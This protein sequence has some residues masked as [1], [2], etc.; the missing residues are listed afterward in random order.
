MGDQDIRWKQ[1]FDSFSKALRQ[2]KDGVDL[3]ES[4]SLS[5][6]EEQGLIQG[7]EFT[8]ELAWK[9]LKDF[10]ESK[11]NTVLYGSK[12]VTRKAYQLELIEDGESWMQMIESRNLSSHTYNE[13]T[14]EKIV[15]EILTKYY[16]L[17]SSLEVKMN[18]L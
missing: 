15:S 11:G 4:R 6:L 13:E 18:E 14:A 3:A 7:F 10:I 8:H 9:T 17:F 5:R 12:D 16:N 1:R 2:L